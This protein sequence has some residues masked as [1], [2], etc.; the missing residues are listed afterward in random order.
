MRKFCI[1]F[2]GIVLYGQSL[3]AQTFEELV[4]KSY[5]YSDSSDL[6]AAEESL[7]AAMRL[8]PAN[9]LNF[10]L[11]TNLGTIQRRQGKYEDALISYSAAL[12]QRPKDEVI[13]LNRAKLYTE[14]GEA[15][16]AIFDYNTLIDIFPTHEEGL[17]SRGLLYI[18]TG[19][20]VLA[21]TDFN[22][23]LKTYDDTFLGRFGYAILEKARGSY[24]NSEIIFDYLAEKYPDN[25]RIFEERAELYFLTKR[26]ARAISDL[27][28]VFA[29]T[30]EPSAELYMLR[31]RIKL[32]QREKESAAIDFRKARDMGY[33]AETVERMLKESF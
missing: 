31:G 10:A 33:D 14:V 28:K 23:I 5:E 32:A 9:K 17:F 8:E 15:E 22:F 6:P 27:N 20:Y 25:M 12:S 2:I 7:K 26:N 18:N 24:D 30:T 29:S 3:Q 19:Q 1:V 13:L 4:I 11:L 21:E 16:K